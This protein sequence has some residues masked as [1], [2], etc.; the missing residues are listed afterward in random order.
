MSLCTILVAFSMLLT[1]CTVKQHEHDFDKWKV[2]KEPTCTK[3]GEK[4]RTCECGEKQTRSISATGEHTYGADN[5]CTQCGSEREYTKELEY[6]VSSDGTGV[7]ITGIESIE[8]PV[9]VI[10]D[11]IDGVPVTSIGE[12]AFYENTDMTS[13]IIP[14]SVT[15]IGDYAFSGCASLSSVTIPSGVTSIGEGAFMNCTSITSIAIPDGVEVIE[16]WA[17]NNCS[18]LEYVVIPTSVTAIKD[19]SFDSCG[20]LS[21]I[22]YEG[23]ASEWNNIS[24]YYSE[25]L[26]N[27]DIT[28]YYYSEAEPAD[29]GDFWHYVDGAPT[30]WP[31]HEH[32]MV[33]G[34][35][36][37]CG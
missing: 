28:L 8:S 22:Y 14:N 32:I 36:T 20:S 12:N 13:V 21:E 2:T 11:K 5:K 25:D 19:W 18:S 34:F 27:A 4:T 1:S 10:P 15:S 35:C 9:V 24:I 6:E 29:D 23:G 7:T 30:A 3:E 26:Y 17:F 33:D 37:A 31:K 16:F